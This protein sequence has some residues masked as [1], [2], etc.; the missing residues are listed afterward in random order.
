MKLPN[1]EQLRIE[2]NKV[3][4]YLLSPANPRGRSKAHFF[5]GF[6]FRTDGWERL[7]KALEVHAASYEVTRV[8]ETSYGPRYYVEGPIET[9][10]GRN[11]VVRTVW[12]VDLGSTH[13]RLITAHPLRR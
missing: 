10:D 7:A 9:P 1:V 12:Q 2:P 5:L 4:A 13:P 6:G 11:P 3:T 8:I